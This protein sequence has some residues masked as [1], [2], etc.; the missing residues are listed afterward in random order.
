[1]DYLIRGIDKELW[2]KVKII[3]VHKEITIKSLLIKILSEYVNRE[4]D[5]IHKTRG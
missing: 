2:K 3:S 5:A 1:M 4:Y